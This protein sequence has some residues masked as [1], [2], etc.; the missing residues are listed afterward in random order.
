[1][2]YKYSDIDAF[3]WLAYSDDE[4]VKVIKI[5]NPCVLSVFVKDSSFG[6]SPDVTYTY[7]VVYSE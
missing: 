6:F 2:A 3:P 5:S 7:F 1:M 4:A